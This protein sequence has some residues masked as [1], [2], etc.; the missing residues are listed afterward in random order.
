MSS[1]WF[2]LAVAIVAIALVVAQDVVPTT[3][4]FHTWQYALALALAAFVMVA[5]VLGAR[6]GEDGAFGRRLALAH[7]GALIVL[8]AGLAS[9]LLGPDTETIVRAPGTVAPLPD[10]GRAAFF[11]PADGAA[12]ARGDTRVLLRK[13]GAG[14]ID[15]APG[16]KRYLAN[17]VLF[18]QPAHAAFVDAYDTRGNHLTVTQPESSAFLS[19]I[20]LF[21]N[22]ATIA[23]KKLPFDTFRTPGAKRVIRAI[24][25]SAQ[26]TAT[27]NHVDTAK[28]NVP[29]VLFAVDD[30]AGKTLGIAIGTSGTIV[31]VGGL[32]L[33]ASIGTYP[34]LVVASAPTPI[35]LI[36]GLVIF[37]GG[38]IWAAF[39][40]PPRAAF[41]QAQPTA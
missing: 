36:A 34:A 40:L 28:K 18:T 21:H 8:G 3:P 6:R 22:E 2:S 19:P 12:V 5:Y 38:L 35:A 20:L 30:D 14:E 23:G 33:R 29:T 13:R 17:S 16:E 26:D 41:R 37:L 7:V 15:I 1:R 25:F 11:A 24:Y 39:A 31:D 9:G 27:M 4:L 10:L 32:H